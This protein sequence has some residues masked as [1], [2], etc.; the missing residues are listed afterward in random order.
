MSPETLC[1]ACVVVNLLVTVVSVSLTRRRL[2][3]IE[4][5]LLARTAPHAVPVAG[6]LAD[7]LNELRGIRFGAPMVRVAG[8]SQHDRREGDMGPGPETEL[9]PVLRDRARKE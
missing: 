5:L 6:G 4:R 7:R 2:A 8:R 9:R 3:R 1:T